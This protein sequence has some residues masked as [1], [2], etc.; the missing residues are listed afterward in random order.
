MYTQEDTFKLQHLL[1][2]NLLAKRED[3]EDLGNAAVKELS[4]QNK[5]A[6]LQSEWA[7]QSLTFAEHKARGPVLIRPA[8]Y[9]ELVEKLE[10]SQMNLSS[11]ATNRYSKPFETTVHEWLIKLGTVSEIMEQWFQVQNVWT[12]MEAVFSGGDIVK[13]LPAEAKRFQNI[14]KNF[15]KIVAMAIET[16]NV[17]D[18]CNGNELMKTMLP[19][20]QARALPHPAHAAVQP[21]CALPQPAPAGLL[22]ALQRENIVL[23]TR[24]SRDCLGRQ[25]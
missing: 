5:L 9:G 19:H 22:K 17:V 11:M 15:M 10:E 18:I 12:Y 4:I 24:A 7:V 23:T 25:A 16:G 6:V 13:Q 2:A 8:D 21:V 1:D 14:D 3:I 20:L